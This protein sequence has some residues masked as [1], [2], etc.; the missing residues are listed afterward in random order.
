MQ[1][2]EPDLLGALIQIEKLACHWHD[3]DILILTNNNQD[4]TTKLL[5]IWR[6]RPIHCDEKQMHL[7]NMKESFHSKKYIINYNDSSLPKGLSREDRFVFYRNY[8]LDYVTL[9]LLNEKS[10]QLNNDKFEY[11]SWM[12]ID[13]DIQGLEQF[14]I[15]QEFSIASVMLNVDVFCVNGMEW[16][17]RYRDTFATVFHGLFCVVYVCIDI[18]CMNEYLDGQWCYED[19][20]QCSEIIQE[21]RFTQVRSCFG[22]LSIYR[23]DSIMQSKC[24]YHTRGELKNNAKITH[25]WF[26]R[27]N[28][29][30][31][32]LCEHIAFHDCLYSQY[33]ENLTFIISRESYLY[34]GFDQYPKWQ[35][36]PLLYSPSS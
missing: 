33:D 27:Q 2:G 32:D 21:N 10:K 25:E 22:G 26:N 7:A 34:Y 12:M 24:R 16:T 30:F 18:K 23:F 13:F 15:F 5:D 19:G 29:K 6:K 4:N 8:I 9:T 14:R 31:I 20:F 35:I 36:E 1:S 3:Y 28:P 17:G 11:D